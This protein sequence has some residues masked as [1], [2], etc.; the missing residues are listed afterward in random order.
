MSVRIKT[1]AEEFQTS[2]NVRKQSLASVIQS[3]YCQEP[4]IAQSL[5]SSQART[6]ISTTN[7]NCEQLRIPTEDGAT[8]AVSAVRS[9]VIIGKCISHSTNIGSVYDTRI[10]VRW[11][12]LIIAAR[13]PTRLRLIGQER[14]AI[15]S[16]TE[17][18]GYSPLLDV[19]VVDKR[20][21]AAAKD[22]AGGGFAIRRRAA[23]AHQTG[24][25]IDLTGHDAKGCLS[26]D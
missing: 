15:E 2:D 9:Y 20:P 23:E 1:H 21:S 4:V 25:R 19:A 12:N 16:G 11:R 5:L 24:I 26:V 22:V 14:G 10:V 17:T 8:L 13:A 3:E 18:C 7:S 6:R